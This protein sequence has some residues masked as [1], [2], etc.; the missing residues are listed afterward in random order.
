[1][2]MDATIVV[3]DD[4]PS[5]RAVTKLALRRSGFRVVPI[6]DPREALAA[7]QRETPTVVML[8]YSMPFMSGLDVAEQL[9]QE[10]GAACPPMLM[11]TG[12][13][14]VVQRDPSRQLLVGLLAKPVSVDG[15]LAELRR[16]IGG[17]FVSGV[18]PVVE[19]PESSTG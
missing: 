7:V 6:G 9:K 2:F 11:V 13:P 18:I 8:D 10:L 16:V 12:N 5:W 14:E 17:R 3:V 1:M 4:D 15:L 19:H